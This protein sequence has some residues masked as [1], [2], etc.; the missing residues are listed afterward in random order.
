[1]VILL[2]DACGFLEPHPVN[3]PL[4]LGIT[5]IGNRLPDALGQGGRTRPTQNTIRTR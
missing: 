4:I 5:A 3:S 1:M 2:E